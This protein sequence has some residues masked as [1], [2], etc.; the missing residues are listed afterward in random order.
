VN[1]SFHV[2]L[3][4]AVDDQAPVTRFPILYPGAGGRN[5]LSMSSP[6]LHQLA[7]V[8]S[9]LFAGFVLLLRSELS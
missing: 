3:L 8:P 1:F 7:A 5:R 9:A 6:S 2:Q 4:F